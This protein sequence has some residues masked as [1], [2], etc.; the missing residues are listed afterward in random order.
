MTTDLDGRITFWSNGAATLF[1]YQ[2][3]EVMGRHL[4][5][6]YGEAAAGVLEQLQQMDG[7]S[8]DSGE[9]TG[10]RKD[11][12]DVPL[13]VRSTVRWSADGEPCGYIS[14]AL[15]ATERHAARV[16]LDRLWAAIEQ[17]SDSV[18][19]TDADASIEYVNPAFERTTGYSREEVQG[20]NPRILNS[21]TQAAS[22]YESMWST[23]GAGQTW[24]ADLVNRRKDGSTFLEHAAIS[25]IREPSG[26][27]TGYVAVKRDVTEERRR[28]EESARHIRERVLITQTVRGFQDD[29]APSATAE[30]VGRQLSRLSGVATAG[31]F[32]FGPDGRAAPYGFT[33]KG[34]PINDC[35]SV[36]RRRSQHLLEQAQRGPWIANWEDR[37]WHP[38]NS[39]FAESGVVAIAYAPVRHGS[40]VIG[41]LHLSSDE[42]D[43]YDT[44][45]GHLVALVQIADITGALLGARLSELYTSEATRLGISRIISGSAFIPVFQP[46]V[47]LGSGEVVGYEGLTR[48]RDRVRPDLRFAEAERAG[49]GQKLELATLEA[50]LTAARDLP[51]SAWLDLNVSPG[52]VMESVELAR[53]L[54][55]ADRPIVLEV[56]EHERIDDYAGFRSAVER[57]G[58]D[59]RIAVDDAGSGYASLR[60]ILELRPALV[61]LDRALVMGIESDQARRALVA[62]MRRFAGDADIQLIAEGIE[63]EAE[64][65]ALR[66]IEVELGQG[67]LLGRP[68]P[69]REGS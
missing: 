42:S 36:P 9:V 38:Y 64:L 16:S 69:V 55:D 3:H 44:L 41:F 39:V 34:E 13:D 59:V 61:K 66:E 4:E 57:L 50:A 54:Q 5:I 48:F 6:I 58:G 17:S 62:G 11:D 22:V 35:G 14:V 19:I 49:M 60:H 53:L 46:I 10:R 51:E 29:A 67:F 52:L 8:V 32:I 63:T 20:Q 43:A 7:G 33:L 30:A 23:L 18:V 27:T 37:P 40:E 45:A 25:P 12:S 2:T 1:G 15:D 65:E 68:R 28:E 47:D 21:G 31:L 26:R 56:T 24:I